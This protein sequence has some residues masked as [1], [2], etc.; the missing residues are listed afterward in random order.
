M[1]INSIFCNRPKVYFTYIKLLLWFITVINMNKINPFFYKILQQTHKMY[2]KQIV[3]ITNVWHRAQCYF[4]RISK[5]WYL[6][7][8][9]NMN[10]INPF[11]SVISSQTHNYCNLTQSQILIYSPW[12]LIMVPNMK[13]IQPAIM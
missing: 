1:G 4:T 7:T 10:K 13:K 5:T 9:P 8:I 3:I 2:I 6:N 11:F 12:S